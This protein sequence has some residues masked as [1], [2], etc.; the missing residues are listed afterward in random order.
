MD[1]MQQAKEAAIAAIEADFQQVFAAWQKMAPWQY[2][3]KGGSGSGNFGHSGRPGQR[4]GSDDSGGGTSPSASGSSG[5]TSKP[6]A[7][8]IGV[9]TR[10]VS[11]TQ[12]MQIAK[13]R[14]GAGE[15]GNFLANNAGKHFYQLGFKG[16]VIKQLYDLSQLYK[17]GGKNQEVAVDRIMTAL[18]DDSELGDALRA[19]IDTETELAKEKAKGGGSSFNP[20]LPT[21][22]QG[23]G[24]KGKN[25]AEEQQKIE[26]AYNKRKK[27]EEVAGQK[28]DALRA[29]AKEQA[30][31]QGKVGQTVYLGSSPI[32]TVTDNGD[33]V[34]AG[35][36]EPIAWAA[37]L[38]NYYVL[39]G[40]GIPYGKQGQI[41]LLQKDAVPSRKGAA[42]GGAGSGYYGHAGRPGERGGS[43]P[44]GV[45][46]PAIAAD[47]P[48]NRIF[49][50]DVAADDPL[51]LMFADLPH[52]V[53]KEPPPPPKP[54]TFEYNSH[55][56]ITGDLD[57]LKRYNFTLE[58]LGAIVDLEGLKAR[59]EI[60]EDVEFGLAI[61]GRWMDDMKVAGT[62]IRQ[63]DPDGKSARLELLTFQDEY[64]D[65]GLGT[66][67]A[68][69]WFRTLARNGYEKAHL[70][71]D[72]T[73]GRYA[74]AKEGA[75]YEDPRHI[76]VINNRFKAWLTAKEI[77]GLEDWTP[78]FR[79]PMDVATYKHP[80]GHRLKGSDIANNDVPPDMN[81]DLGKAFMLDIERGHDSWDVMID[82][83]KWKER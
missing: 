1:S 79:S 23:S 83:T 66:T 32:Q 69:A 14:L 7:K 81:L 37:I 35:D 41:T 33:T 11:R 80:S 72:L 56:R 47:D 16:P 63:L 10:P 64:L 15:P 61:S 54:K 8:P 22:K 45:G 34:T 68:R 71:A 39:A 3:E 25:Q 46:L 43:S 50:D 74:W 24:K 51:N 30:K 76:N 20:K 53:K 42:K 73:I 17:A 29:Q 36:G 26:D 49:S 27:A 59:V 60:E 78:D 57:A 58:D 9:S 4:G 65:N 5:N 75:Q 40:L 77:P 82:L 70:L 19:Q 6:T 12:A 13:Q 28:K 44:R 67:V 38:D 2:S 31:R 62:F 21:A 52:P 48:L 55:V 18:S